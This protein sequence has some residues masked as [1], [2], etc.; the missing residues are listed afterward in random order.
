MIATR[1]DL[2]IEP[3]SRR[4]AELLLTLLKYTDREA[5]QTLLDSMLSI[6]AIHAFVS[7]M[8]TSLRPLALLIFSLAITPPTKIASSFIYPQALAHVST[9]STPLPTYW[10]TL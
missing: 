2:L 5:K 9:L 10:C 3:N 7:H 1:K 6:P 8:P 4:S